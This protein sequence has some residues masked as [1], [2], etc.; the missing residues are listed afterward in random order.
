MTLIF[1]CE[2][3][4]GRDRASDTGGHQ[5]VVRLYMAEVFQYSPAATIM[6]ELPTLEHVSQ[7]VV[8]RV[9]TR[10]KDNRSD[11]LQAQGKSPF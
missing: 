4:L 3:G 6:A 2:T 5:H 10:N 7:T 8:G 9:G 11:N 1:R